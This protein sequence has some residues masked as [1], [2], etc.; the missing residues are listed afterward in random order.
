MTA[1][2]LWNHSSIALNAFGIILMKIRKVFLANDII[3]YMAGTLKTTDLKLQ[4]PSTVSLKH[5]TNCPRTSA[6][7]RKGVLG[8][9]RPS[10]NKS[11]PIGRSDRKHG[12]TTLRIT[13][14]VSRP[15]AQMWKSVESVRNSTPR[16]RVVLLRSRTINFSPLFDQDT[17]DQYTALITTVHLQQVLFN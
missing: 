9:P 3:L 11:G 16:K 1:K 2:Y 12:K 15:N 17:V 14:H 7:K 6:R 4:S 13:L 5:T 10:S 8:T